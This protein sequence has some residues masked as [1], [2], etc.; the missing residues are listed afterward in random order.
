MR[1]VRVC[2]YRP[3]KNCD[4]CIFPVYIRSLFALVNMVCKTKL[5]QEIYLFICAGLLCS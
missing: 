3:A 4:M 5:K 1:F 2:V